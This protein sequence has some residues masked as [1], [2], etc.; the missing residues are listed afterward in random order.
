MTGQVAYTQRFLATDAAEGDDVAKR[1]VEITRENDLDNG[2]VMLAKTGAC[3]T[4]LVLLGGR[5]GCSPR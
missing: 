2:F 3:H 4:A 1:V 5:G